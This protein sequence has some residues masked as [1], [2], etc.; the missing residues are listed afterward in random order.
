MKKRPRSFWETPLCIASFALWAA[1]F[2]VFIVLLIVCVSTATETSDGKFE[3]APGLI[4]SSAIFM[5]ISG[6]AFVFL[7]IMIIV[8]ASKKKNAPASI[9]EPL[10]KAVCPH[11]G[12]ENLQG[13]EFCRYCG[14]KI[15]AFSSKE[16][17]D[18]A[19]LYSFVDKEIVGV[20]LR[21]K[22]LIFGNL[23]TIIMMGSVLL[24][25]LILSII[26]F[27]YVASWAFVLFLIL[28][29]LMALLLLFTF[30]LT[31]YFQYKQEMKAANREGTGVAIFQDRLEF[32]FHF[33]NKPIKAGTLVLRFSSAR[34]AREDNEGYYF[35]NG[36][37]PRTVFYLSKSTISYAS[38][39]EFLT[40]QVK[41]INE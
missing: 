26:T 24:A 35:L 33:A 29:L 5:C 13:D 21:M 16:T 23:G 4:P 22:M 19:P 28:A 32:S 11:C 31:P 25:S 18:D 1:T 15:E 20:S 41:K 40:S 14:G 3:Y 30:V 17:T 37:K 8:N 34:K 2:F 12:K 36:E 6:L 38:A 39:R 9:P 7:I 10:P 27:F